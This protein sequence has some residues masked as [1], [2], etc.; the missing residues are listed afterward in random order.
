MSGNT[1][2]LALASTT[3]YYKIMFCLE[4]FNQLPLFN[5]ARA[6]VVEQS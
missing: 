4:L 2:L 1:T 5:H 6:E 3:L